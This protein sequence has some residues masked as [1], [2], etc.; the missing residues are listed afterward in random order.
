MC[1]PKL[2]NNLSNWQYCGKHSAH[3]H[4][5]FANEYNSVHWAVENVESKTLRKYKKKINQDFSWVNIIVYI[6]LLNLMRYVYIFIYLW[7]ICLYKCL[8][9]DLTIAG[10]NISESQKTLICNNGNCPSLVACLSWWKYHWNDNKQRKVDLF[11]GK[12]P[13]WL[14]AEERHTETKVV[15]TAWLISAMGVKVKQSK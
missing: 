5:Q 13:S 4:S 12:F 7:Y 14:L 9:T 15:I 3:P 1:Y 2:K 10:K 11:S 6:Y 8:I